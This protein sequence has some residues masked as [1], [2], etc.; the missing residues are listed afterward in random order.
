MEA[1]STQAYSGGEM[2]DWWLDGLKANFARKNTLLTYR[3]EMFTIDGDL[4]PEQITLPTLILHG[5]DDRLAPV[6]IGRY[7][8]EVIPG[9]KLIETPGGSHMIPVTHAE[10]LADAIIAFEAATR[11]APAMPEGEA[12]APGGTGDSLGTGAADY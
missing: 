2:P 6:A 3:G 9:S 7:L 8:D 1:A 11:P 12:M 4:E 5:D 10:E